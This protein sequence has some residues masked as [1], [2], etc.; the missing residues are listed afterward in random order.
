MTSTLS[1]VSARRVAVALYQLDLPAVHPDSAAGCVESII[2]NKSSL[3]KLIETDPAAAIAFINLCRQNNI[4][5]PAAY[6]QNPGAKTSQDVSE[7]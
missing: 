6:K 4:E 5:F 3:G 2:D 7:H 1:N